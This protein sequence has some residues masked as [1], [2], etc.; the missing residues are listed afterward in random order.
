MNKIITTTTNTL[1][2]WTIEEHHEPIS[3]NVFEGYYALS[4]LAD[5]KR[6]FLRDAKEFARNVSSV[7]YW[8]KGDYGI[9][10]PDIKN[11]KYIMSLI[12]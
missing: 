5:L 9:T 12:K 10:L 11:L 8:G 1:E 6:E 2:G 7:G 4:D 3:A